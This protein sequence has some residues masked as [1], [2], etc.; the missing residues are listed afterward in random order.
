[1]DSNNFLQA[2]VA[3]SAILGVIGAIAITGRNLVPRQGVFIWLIF[4]LVTGIL[5]N[6]QE[7]M[8]L[9]FL[10]LCAGAS[11]LSL[12]A[13]IAWLLFLDVN[14]NINLPISGV[15]IDFNRKKLVSTIFLGLVTLVTFIGI[16]I[17]SY[18]RP[19]MLIFLE[20]I[21][22]LE[23][24]DATRVEKLLRTFLSIVGVLGLLISAILGFPRRNQGS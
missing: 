1:M 6:T 10:S 15:N 7:G 18:S 20:K 17:C 11:A 5:V 9:Y 2:K 19:L 24:S 3:L 8:P 12:V 13:A 4:V 23:P 21:L 16:I 22:I 14:A